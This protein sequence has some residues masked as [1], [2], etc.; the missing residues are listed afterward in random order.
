MHKDQPHESARAAH[1]RTHPGL[2]QARTVQRGYHRSTHHKL[3]PGHYIDTETW[4]S[5]ADA[6]RYEEEC[7]AALEARPAS[8]ALSFSSAAAILGM[9]TRTHM[10]KQIHLTY[11][12][13]ARARRYCAIVPHFAEIDVQDLTEVR[14]MTV[15]TPERT[16]IDLCLTAQK[17]YSLGV[18]D[19]LLRQAGS[20]MEEQRQTLFEVL[21]SVPA[22]RGR[23][24]AARIIE[25]ASGQSES[26]GESFLRM[27][28]DELGVVP[29]VLQQEI[30][31][32]RGKYR[33]DFCWPIERVVLEFDG[34]QKYHDP[35]ILGNLTPAQVIMSEKI[36]ESAIAACGYRVAR[37]I[38]ADLLDRTRLSTILKA[39]GIP[40]S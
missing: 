39:S 40:F 30:A 13:D 17:E 11:S 37:L 3:R 36:R 15:T 9:P 28:L 32:D 22:R 38:W 8:I 6:I 23:G 31:T 14:G 18:V 26:P 34:M 21:E 33:V 1:L 24:V 20:R 25:L 29:P 5:S 27:R 16:A 10:L 4:G 19:A 35:T 2:G 12:Q 7:R